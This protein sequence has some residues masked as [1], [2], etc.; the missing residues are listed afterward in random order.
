MGI[1]QM[2]FAQEDVLMFDRD[3]MLST[4]FAFKPSRIFRESIT[5]YYIQ[6]SMSVYLQPK[7]SIRGDIAFSF[8]EYVN[9]DI[10]LRNHSIFFGA[11]YHFTQNGAFDPFIGFQP[12]FSLFDRSNFNNQPINTKMELIPN[13]SVILGMKFFVSP[14]FNFFTNIRYVYGQPVIN[15]TIGSGLHEL[16]VAFGLGLNLTKK[17][18]SEWLPEN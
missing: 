16:R 10:N 15:P 11:C 8:R 3:K 18:Y 1:Y 7:V 5:Q 12:G 4:D 6:G 14:F 13:A 2:N 9:K 17:K